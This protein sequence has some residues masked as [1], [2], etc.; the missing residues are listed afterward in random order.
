MAVLE[1]RIEDDEWRW[2]RRVKGCVAGRATEVDMIMIIYVKVRV[3]INDDQA[4]ALALRW[5][6]PY[7]CCGSLSRK[8]LACC[9]LIGGSCLLSSR[10]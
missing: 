3:T 7:P 4:L 9:A 8:L 6:R 10:R 2:R 5:P 1:M